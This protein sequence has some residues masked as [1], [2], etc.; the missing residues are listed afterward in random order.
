MP[1]KKADTVPPMPPGLAET[2]P[3]PKRADFCFAALLM[4]VGDDGTVLVD[5]ASGWNSGFS[6]PEAQAEFVGVVNRA[7]P[8]FAVTKVVGAEIIPAESTPPSPPVPPEA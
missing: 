3:A 7:Y 6:Q 8:G 1:P 4:R 5:I 2:L